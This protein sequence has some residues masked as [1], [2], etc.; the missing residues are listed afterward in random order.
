MRIAEIERADFVVIKN[1]FEQ[2][3]Q[4][5]SLKWLAAERDRLREYIIKTLPDGESVCKTVE[6]EIKSAVTAEQGEYKAI[7]GSSIATQTDVS[8]PA[9]T[10]VA[11]LEEALASQYGDMRESVF[12]V[13]NLPIAVE[14]S[15]FIPGDA[16]A[17]DSERKDVNVQTRISLRSMDR[18][19]AIEDIVEGSTVL[20]IWND[21]HNA[22]MLFRWVTA[23][24]SVMH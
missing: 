24:H 21:R 13:E 16:P 2:N 15:V 8:Y 3:F 7:Y 4:N 18:M 19:V 6:D 10:S 9:I 22:Y 11:P 17:S 20:V 14:E 1:I 23:V 12:T 5:C